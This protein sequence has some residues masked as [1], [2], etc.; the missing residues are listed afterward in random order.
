MRYI[1][2]VSFFF[3]S[4]PWHHRSQPENLILINVIASTVCAMLNAFSK[5]RECWVGKWCC[6]VRFSGSTGFSASRFALKM[7][8]WRLDEVAITI[9]IPFI[10]IGVFFV[11]IPSSPECLCRMRQN[12][13]RVENRNSNEIKTTIPL[14]GPTLLCNLVL[15]KTSKPI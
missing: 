15:E 1:V 13:T 3:R 4:R 10:L 5:M 7:A 6:Y 8:Q 9:A 14:K 2:E 12:R 11:L